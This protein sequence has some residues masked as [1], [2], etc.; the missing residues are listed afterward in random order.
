MRKYNRYLVNESDRF[1]PANYIS[2]GIEIARINAQTAAMPAGIK[3]EMLLSFLKN[4]SIP[5]ALATANPQLVKLIESGSLFTGDIE[6]L[7]ES[8]Q[9]HTNFSSQL[10]KHLRNSFAEPVADP[11]N[12]SL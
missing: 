1:D 7:F 5:V 8:A 9:P 6:A 12:V 3:V 11:D 10:E 4:H 2:M